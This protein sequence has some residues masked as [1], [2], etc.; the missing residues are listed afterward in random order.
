MLHTRRNAKLAGVRADSLCVPCGN[1]RHTLTLLLHLAHKPFICEGSTSS[2]LEPARK[3]T[4]NSAGKVET[5]WSD[6]QIWCRSKGT[7]GARKG[8]IRGTS[9]G[10]SSTEGQYI[11]GLAPRSR[12]NSR[13]RERC[14]RSQAR[15]PARRDTV[16]SHPRA[17]AIRRVKADARA[18]RSGLRERWRP[19]RRCSGRTERSASAQSL[20][21]KGCSRARSAHRA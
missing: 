8:R 3:S 18:E 14:S 21:A 1:S 17:H 4:G 12:D 13:G 15:G 20:G 6:G 10:C 19:L 5:A 2:S 11:G 9:W 7:N 16:S